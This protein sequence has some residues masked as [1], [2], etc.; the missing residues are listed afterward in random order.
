MR[1]AA[2]AQP[3]SVCHQWSIT[4]TLRMRSAQ[5]QGVRVAALAG[6]EQALRR[7]LRS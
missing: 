4:G 6:E 7:V 1:L 5:I 3:V 2:I